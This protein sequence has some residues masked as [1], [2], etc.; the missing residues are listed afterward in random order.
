MRS[1]GA[2]RFAAT[3]AI[4]R[5]VLDEVCLCSRA[6]GCGGGAEQKTKRVLRRHNVPVAGQY[7]ACYWRS[8]GAA[9]AHQAQPSLVHFYI[10]WF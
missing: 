1:F 9:V 10:D 7:T 8:S 6:A 5:T 4:A 2:S 3:V